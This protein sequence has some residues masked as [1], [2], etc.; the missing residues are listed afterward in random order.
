MSSEID[1]LSGAERMLAQAV[2]VEDFRDII[3]QAELARV[4]AR[5]ARL[6]NA[7]INHATLIRV[8]AERGLAEA[9][10][11][12]QRAGVIA[13]S[14]SH[15]RG[16]RSRQSGPE[17]GP[18]S[19]L[20]LPAT[21]AELGVKKQRV[22]EA[23]KL[24]DGFTDEELTQLAEEANAR[25]RALSR[26]KLVKEAAARK[27]AE[28]RER[29]R[30]AEPLPDGA[31][32]RVGDAR[33]VLDD[34]PDSSVALVLTDPPYGDESRPLYE[35]LAEW[36]AR[37]LVP[38]GSLICYTGQSR[39]DQ[40]LTALG[41]HLRYWWLLSMQHTRAQRLPGKFV[42]AEFK[43]VLWYVK[44]YR[45]GRTLVNDVLRPLAP[46]K[47]H[48][49]GQGEAGV[50]LLIE[51]LTEPGELIADPFAGSETWGKIAANMGRRWIGADQADDF[52]AGILA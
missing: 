15:G 4:F 37:V 38:G 47:D 3:D 19:G 8:R 50:S 51:Q 35:W 44:D 2:T 46:D 28:R 1:L 17:S 33:E 12:G 11:A 36:S 13:T 43:P 14:D 18:D 31:E 26:D 32:R 27:T 52:T 42:I 7:S 40:D 20:A 30:S 16:G 48:E 5:R 34:V 24:R 22:E 10:D 25:D 39:L 9:I 23:R 21:L 41:Q 6:G 29:S 45:R 49:W